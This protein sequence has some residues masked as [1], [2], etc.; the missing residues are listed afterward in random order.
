M[1]ES[2]TSSDMR[3]ST[4]PENDP[5][6]VAE[7]ELDHEPDYDSDLDE[8]AQ[9]SRFFLL[10]ARILLAC[11]GVCLVLMVA[12]ALYQASQYYPKRFEPVESGKLYRSGEVT[13]EQLQRLRDDFAIS[14]VICLLDPNAPITQT[15]RD[16]AESLDVEWINLPMGG[17]GQHKAAQIPQLVDLLIDGNAPPTLVHCAAGVNRT[18][19]AV[20]LYRIHH[21]G[22]SYE[23]VYEELLSHDF[24]DLPKHEQ[25]RETLRQE[26]ARAAE[27]RSE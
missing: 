16:A 13:R 26:A 19:L 4:L 9:D 18:G 27:S 11:V 22:W 1:S 5:P 15:E 6:S 8:P 24:D 10:R 25:L 3:A 7:T 17:S 20:G 23:Q 21:D 2:R 12:A 14:R